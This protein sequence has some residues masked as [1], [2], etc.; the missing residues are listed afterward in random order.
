[1]LHTKRIDCRRF[2]RD[3]TKMIGGHHSW[4]PVS[5][6][7]YA[8]KRGTPHLGDNLT[9]MEIADMRNERPVE[10]A[11]MRGIVAYPKTLDWASAAPEKIVVGANGIFREQI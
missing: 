4:G 5:M 11:T 3:G 6:Y 9:K 1:M 7:E 8:Q 2:Q 10:F